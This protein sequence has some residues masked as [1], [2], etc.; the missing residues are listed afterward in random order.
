MNPIGE[1]LPRLLSIPLLWRNLLREMQGSKENSGGEEEKSGH[2][3]G[4]QNIEGN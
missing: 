2:V 3:A 1:G 4:V